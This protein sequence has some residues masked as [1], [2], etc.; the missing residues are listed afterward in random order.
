MMATNVVKH[1]CPNCG[2]VDSFEIKDFELIDKD[3][4]VTCYCEE[5]K[6]RWQDL[7]GLFYLGYG[8]EDKIFDRDGLEIRY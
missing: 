4:V 1:I 7:Y 5:C 2:A 3:L 6:K 8:V